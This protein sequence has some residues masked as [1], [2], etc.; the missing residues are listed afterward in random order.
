MDVDHRPEMLVVYLV[1]FA[2][3]SL[4]IGIAYLAWF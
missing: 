2:T 3:A 1:L 4:A